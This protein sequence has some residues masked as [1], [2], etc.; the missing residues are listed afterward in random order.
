MYNM[1]IHLA[2][3]WQPSK[4]QIAA[5]ASPVHLARFIRDMREMYREQADQ[6][7]FDRGTKMMLDLFRPEH[8]L[9]KPKKRRKSKR[10]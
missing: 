2:Q 8:D 9:P 6:Y 10:I 5:S 1:L 3:T 4:D 7:R